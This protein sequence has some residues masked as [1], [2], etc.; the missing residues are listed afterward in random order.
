MIKALCACVRACRCVLNYRERLANRYAAA[1][2][3]PTVCYKK[4]PH[5]KGPTVQVHYCNCITAGGAL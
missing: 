2:R 4:L 3:R 5:N 1:A